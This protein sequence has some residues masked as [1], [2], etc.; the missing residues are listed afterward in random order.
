MDILQRLGGRKFLMALILIGV[1][2]YIEI[3]HP[4]GL[5]QNLVMLFVGVLG[6]F[7]AANH[8][9]SSVYMKTRSSAGS[10]GLDAETVSK[11]NELHAIAKHSQ[12]PNNPN[13]QDLRNLLAGINNG[14]RQVQETTSQVGLSVVNM[15]KEVMRIKNA[16]A[17]PSNF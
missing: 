7:S 5:S 3:A 2:S 11:L 10:A 1:G 14:V 6:A 13:T 9:T 15:N 4:G 12:D 17:Q 16:V 8:A